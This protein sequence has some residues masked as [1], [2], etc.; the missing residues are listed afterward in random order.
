MWSLKQFFMR[1]VSFICTIVSVLINVKHTES[2]LGFENGFILAGG[3]KMVW[4]VDVLACLTGISTSPSA[5]LKPKYPRTA[6]TVVDCTE[7]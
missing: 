5:G 6:K 7:E 4:S 3:S 2:S 1:E